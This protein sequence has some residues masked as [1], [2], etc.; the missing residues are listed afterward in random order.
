MIVRFYIDTSVFGGY[1]DVEFEEETK[2]FFDELNKRQHH[3]VVSEEV[4]RE[5]I[6]AQARVTGLFLSLSEERVE[7]IALDKEIITLA[8]AYVH[9]GALTKRYISDA[10]HIAC[11]TLSKVD[12]L[13]SWNFTHM[14]NFFRIKQYN[15]INRKFGYAPIDIRSPKEVRE[16]NNIS[17]AEETKA[18]YASGIRTMEMVRQI[19]DELS[20]L[21]WKN[22]DAYLTE[23]KKSTMD[24]IERFRT[25]S[26]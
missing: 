12:V 1:F 4:I 22:P 24:I 11:A 13:V 26:K 25:K 20:E 21:Y 3:V 6:K 5:I 23:L 10:L 18:A 2:V 17:K 14:V 15:E 9:Q 16:N 7:I 19:R 8:D